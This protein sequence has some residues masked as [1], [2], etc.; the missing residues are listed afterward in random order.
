M[1]AIERAIIA[2]A[3]ALGAFTA[4]PSAACT[5]STTG[6]S[7]GAYDQGSAP[8]DGVGTVEAAC[9]PSEKGP[10]I[11]FSTGSSGNFTTRRLTAGSLRLNYNLYTNAARNMVWGNGGGGSAT[12]T[13]TTSSVTAGTRT[14]T[15]AIYGRIPA[16]QK[17]DPGVYTDT[18][19]M[20]VTF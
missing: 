12:V 15:R 6:V 13:M 3:T 1:R 18:I 10:T 17:P 4:A 7:F 19:V 9:H 16:G 8:T 14:F 2:V 20:T 11:S 5:L